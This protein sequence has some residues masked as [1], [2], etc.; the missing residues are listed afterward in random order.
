M[1]FAGEA[2]ALPSLAVVKPLLLTC[3]RD[4]AALFTELR[5]KLGDGAAACGALHASSDGVG[6][7]GGGEPGATPH[8]SAL[9]RTIGHRLFGIEPPPNM[10]ASL[11]SMFSGGAAQDDDDE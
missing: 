9:L 8:P 11:L 3:E 7:G 6:R 1:A 10:M 5:Q 4:A 2:Q